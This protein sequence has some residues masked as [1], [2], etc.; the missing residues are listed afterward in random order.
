[1]GMSSHVIGFKPPNEKW[2]QMKQVRESCLAAGIS[3][4]AEVDKFFD[5]EEP[6]EAGV[7]VKIP[8]HESSDSRSCSDIF[9]VYL[10]DIPKDVTILRFINSY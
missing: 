10:K 5:Y 1:M 7:Q 9:E 3:I 2:K 6:D 8:V 4:P